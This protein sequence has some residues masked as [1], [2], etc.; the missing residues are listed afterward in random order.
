MSVSIR[1]L[2]VAALCLTPITAFADDPL[3][4]ISVTGVGEITLPADQAVVRVGVQSGG[5]T[6]AEAMNGA[7]DATAA[8]LA[9]LAQSGIA[10]TDVQ[11]QGL[12]LTPMYKRG[13]TGLD[14]TQISGY[15]AQNSV[16]VT[17]QDLNGLGGL[18]AGIVELGGNRI[19]GIS[20]GLADPD[21]YQDQARVLA[22]QDARA[23]AD[24]YAGAAG[25]EVDGV[26]SISE[27]G[28]SGGVLYDAMPRM[29]MAE[30]AV[31]DVPLAAGEITV[32]ADVSI[33]FEIGD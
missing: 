29:M 17:T 31:S 30:S 14:Y 13:L 21:S 23:R 9:F 16:S 12:R 8:I 22:V 7:S 28:Y 6:S 27:N 24:L 32:T 20:F 1:A 2:G 11:T 15:S 18:L 25:V 19:D 3:R 26:I 5:A 33:V 4:T 10:P